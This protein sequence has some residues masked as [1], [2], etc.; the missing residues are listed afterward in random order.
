VKF[1]P[2]CCPQRSFVLTIDGNIKHIFKRWDLPGVRGANS[3]KRSLPDDL[4]AVD[5]LVPGRRLRSDHVV[6]F[7]TLKWYFK[8]WNIQL[9]FLIVFSQSIDSIWLPSNIKQIY[10][11][12]ACT[13]TQ[14][15]FYS[16][17][18]SFFYLSLLFA[19]FNFIC[20]RNKFSR[21]LLS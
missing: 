11:N 21:Y 10:V 4:R 3:G 20:E 6:L 16:I 17:F 13:Y 12:K 14:K 19:F 5:L 15:A 7:P 2:L 8:D 18:V 1:Q 9:A